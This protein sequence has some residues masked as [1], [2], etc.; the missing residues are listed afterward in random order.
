MAS[1]IYESNIRTMA[2]ILTRDRPLKTP[3]LDPRCLSHVNFMPLPSLLVPTVPCSF[4]RCGYASSYFEQGA[5]Y[6]ATL[7]PLT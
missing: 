7:V 1:R 4:P 3:A 5:L 6:S 2:I